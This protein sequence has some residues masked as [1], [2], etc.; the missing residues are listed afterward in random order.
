MNHW[1]EAWRFGTDVKHQYAYT[2]CMDFVCK[3]TISY[4]VTVWNFDVMS[5]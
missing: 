4:I 3:S 1:T 5:D 2:L